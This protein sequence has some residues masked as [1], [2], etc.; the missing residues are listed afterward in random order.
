[1]INLYKIKE[2]DVEY[3]LGRFNGD[4][5]TYDFKNILVYLEA[6]GKILFGEHFEI[7]K[8]DHKLLLKLCC[9]FIQDKDYCKANGIDLNKGILLS[10]PVGC[11]K[12]SLMNLLR[13]LSLKPK[14]F[15]IIAARNIVFAYNHLGT[16]TIQDFGNNKCYC[17]D[18]L[19]IEP[20]GKYYGS[21]YNVMGEVL[22][23]R[24]ELFLETK[25]K[26]HITTNLNAT[27][28][29]K[30]YGSR[31]RSRMRQLFNQLTFNETTKDKRK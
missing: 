22:L 12:T 27:E 20:V 26:T 17:F 11:G 18:D 19:G 28:I 6:K 9:Y 15:E 8:E 1:M 30:R 2:G 13:N 25:I 3:T 29:E 10:G 4:T 5:V 14:M 16:K 24:Y 7:H 23:S 31:V 21:T